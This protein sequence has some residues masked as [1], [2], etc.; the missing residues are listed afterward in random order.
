MSLMFIGVFFL[1]G[2]AGYFVSLHVNNVRELQHKAELYDA[3]H[4]KV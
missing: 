3:E 1:G 2:V 4:E